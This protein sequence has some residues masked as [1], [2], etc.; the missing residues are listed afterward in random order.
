MIDK[1]DPSEQPSPD[2]GIKRTV[3]S[4]KDWASDVSIV[5]E[6]N[7]DANKLHDAAYL[8]RRSRTKKL[9]DKDCTAIR[10]TALGPCWH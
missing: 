8:D 1:V 6:V 7:H 5:R 10:N 2:G 4:D 3:L 9:N